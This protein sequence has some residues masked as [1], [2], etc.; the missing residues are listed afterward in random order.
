[1]SRIRATPIRVHTVH[2]RQTL[3]GNP[4]DSLD[5]FRD[6]FPVLIAHHRQRHADVTLAILAIAATRD[7]VD[8]GLLE[9]PRGKPGAGLALRDGRPDV[10]SCSWLRDIPAHGVEAVHEDVAAAL[11]EFE[12]GGVVHAL[13]G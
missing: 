7:H 1:M 6:A 8:G 3:S 5:R 4:L 11:D 12:C 10:E 9:E 2:L 13:D